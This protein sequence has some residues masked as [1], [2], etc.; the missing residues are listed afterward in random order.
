M[1]DNRNIKMSKRIEEFLLNDD[2]VFMVVGCAHVIG[3]NGII[4]LLDGK[5]QISRVK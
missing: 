1:Y 4:D 2:R 5:Y 3:D